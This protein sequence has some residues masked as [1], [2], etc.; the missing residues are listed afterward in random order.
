MT[1]DA[2]LVHGLVFPRLIVQAADGASQEIELKAGLCIGRAEDNDLTLTDPKVS[3]HHARIQRQ[4]TTFVLTD[5]ESANG[6]WVND[7]FLTGAHTLE[8]GDRIQ[9]G[10]TE[11]RYRV[12]GRDSEDTLIGTL[13]V[14]AL[15]TVTQPQPLVVPPPSE[16]Q[17]DEG[18]HGRG[19][20]I[21]LGIAGILLVAALIVAA[22]YWLA[23]DVFGPAAP[24]TP[25]TQTPQIVVVPRSSET[26]PAETPETGDTPAASIDFEQKLEEAGRLARRSQFEPAIELFQDLTRENPKDARPYTEW[27]WALIWDYEPGKALPYAQKATELDPT[28]AA[29]AAALAWAHVDSGDVEQGLEQAQQAVELDSG[30][31]LAHT[32]LAYAYMADGQVQ[33]AVDEADLAL[34]QDINAADAHRVRGWLYLIAADDMGRA[35][36]ELQI[37]AGLQPDLWLR[38]HELGE[39]LLEAGDNTT[40]IMAFQDALKI[41]PKAVTYTAIGD[42]YYRLGQYDQAKASLDQAQ[43]AGAQDLRSLALLGITYARLDRC[44]DAAPFYEDALEMDAT[45][46]LAL[47]AQE[48]CKGTGPTAKPSE[49]AGTPGAPA[50]T[51][52]TTPGAQVTPRPTAGPPSA[53]SGRMAFPVWNRERGGYDVYIAQVDGSNRRL[54]VEQMHQPALS[55]DGSWLTVNG[56]RPD[57]MNLFIVQ[58]NGSGLKEISRHLEDSLPVWSPDGQSLAFSSTMHGDK[59]SRVYVIDSV[60]FVGR[61]V[62]GRALNF[63]PDDVRGQFPA[64]TDD[65][66]IVY[67]GCDLTVE[68]ARC[69][70]YI[71]PSAPGPHPTTQLTEFAQD[72][73]PAVRG[74]QIA[75]AS[76]REGNWD[77]YVM[78]LDGSDVQRLTDSTSNEG[79]PVWSPDGKSLAYVSNQGGDWAIWAMNANGSNQRRLFALGDGGLASDWQNE[80][81]SWAP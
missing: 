78:N 26:A 24:T 77:V 36:G 62:E 14:T 74:D 79:L 42:A 75:F 31:A 38:R 69:G 7:V 66:R 10:D 50:A 57:H 52:G 70:L 19:V 41:R 61:A 56:E 49:T 28:S 32:A 33:K 46:P 40:A 29:A 73:A 48:L 59:Q 25:P 15:P 43:A 58:S 63:G 3:R 37:A 18:P 1:E 12:P 13:P 60:P 80:R 11:L 54:V 17:R 67:Q 21:A 68:P 76:N 22:I 9:I 5:L 6:T 51:P 27:A 16:S 4:G 55:P 47:E 64:W 72:S 30:N 65:G 35:A 81:I 20:M 23:P 8:H 44:K 45:E 71:M 34:V 2:T 39:L 53:L